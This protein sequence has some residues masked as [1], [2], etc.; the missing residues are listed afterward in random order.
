MS[1]AELEQQGQEQ[2]ASGW[3]I[4]IGFVLFSVSLIGFPYHVGNQF[5]PAGG[6]FWGK[7]RSLFIHRADIVVP[8]KLDSWGYR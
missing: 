5:V 8:E 6:G 7:L 2:R 1:K 4:K 3:Q